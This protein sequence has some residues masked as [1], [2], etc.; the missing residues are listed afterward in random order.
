MRTGQAAAV[1]FR[2]PGAQWEPRRHP[3]IEAGGD[4]QRHRDTEPSGHGH[5]LSHGPPRLL[6]EMGTEVT[7]RI[8]AILDELPDDLELSAAVRSYAVAGGRSI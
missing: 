6:D 3:G 1:T 5:P 2:T 8:R 7:R 4:S